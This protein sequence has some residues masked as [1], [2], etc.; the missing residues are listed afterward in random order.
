[1]LLGT[2]LS[3]GAFVTGLHAAMAVSAGTFALAAVVALV[4]VE[5]RAA[6]EASSA[7]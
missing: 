6:G 5:T 7:T 1:V 4:S 2:L 3:A